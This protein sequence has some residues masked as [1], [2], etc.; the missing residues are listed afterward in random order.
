MG[1]TPAR[2]DV[3]DGLYQQETCDLCIVGG[4]IAG[5]N[6]LFAAS[7]YLTRQHRVLLV[8]KHPCVGGMWRETYDYV[9]LHQPHPMF[10][11]GNIPWTLDRDPS[12]L[13]TKDE[14]LAHFRH[15]LETLR[16]RIDLVERYGYAY[17]EHREIATRDGVGAEVLCHSVGGDQ[18]PLLIRASRLVKALGYQIVQNDP[19]QFSSER[20]RSVAPHSGAFL[21]DEMAESDSPV[22]VIGGGKTAMDTA[23]AL[24]QKFPEKPVYLV[25]GGGTVFLNRDQAFPKGLRRWWAGRRGFSVGLDLALR[26]NGQNEAE[27]I[28]YFREKYG[29]SPSRSCTNYR[30]GV[31]SEEEN[32]A[33]CNG[34]EELIPEYLSDVV[35]TDTEIQMIFRSGHSRPIEPGSWVV[36]CTGHLAKTTHPYEPYLSARGAVLSIQPTSAIHFLT[37]FSAYLLTHLFFLGKLDD[38]PLY[39]L[40]QEELAAK[41]PVAWPLVCITLSLHN[42]ILILSVVP[43]RVTR[44]FGLDFDRWFPLHRRLLSLLAIKRHGA[45]YVAHCKRTLDRVRIRHG[46]RCGVLQRGPAMRTAE[47]APSH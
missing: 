20:V 24:T 5:M 40:D 7:S 3:A 42:V 36:N 33:I 16:A 9:R 4:G 17:Q 2:P 29:I 18:R 14:V 13:A 31:L 35:D 28:Q 44:E 10:T 37:T 43:R 19:L 27:V 46:V 1:S 34:V 6:A 47:G 15:C 45:R 38:L 23:Y 39:E 30:F 32:E 12:Y 11:A 8:D 25:V 21:G 22:Y 41:A 26:Y